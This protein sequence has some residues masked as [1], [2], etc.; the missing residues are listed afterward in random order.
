MKNSVSAFDFHIHSHYSYDSLSSI[1]AIYKI[2]KKREL[3]GFAI[4]DHNTLEGAMKASSYNSEIITIIG[5][6][7]STN[8]GDII[9]LFLNEEIQPGDIHIVI[10]KIR[11]QDGLVVLPHPF[12]K[13]R[14]PSS[15]IVAMVDII[16][17]LN[18]RISQDENFLA[19][20][21]AK[22]YDLQGIGGSDA[23]LSYEVGKIQTVIQQEIT[24]IDEIRKLLKD[25]KKQIF[26]S[27]SSPYVHIPSAIIGTIKTK[28]FR[29]LARSIC[30]KV[31]KEGN[32]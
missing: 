23:H 15:E 3:T 24:D 22:R 10:E 26:G 20:D 1:K 9:G 28:N 5:E 27:E 31:L 17:V 16:E 30:N 29:N 6:E 4:T 11:E 21:L 2:A 18:G 7:I 19:S 25:T 8:Q 32:L 13:N 14:S 12:K